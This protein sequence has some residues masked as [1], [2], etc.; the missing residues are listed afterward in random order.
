MDL[1]VGH[2]SPACPKAAVCVCAC[3]CKSVTMHWVIGLECSGHQVGE[4]AK[5]SSG[6]QLVASC[7][8]SG[9]GSR[10]APS[11]PGRKPHKNSCRR[12]PTPRQFT[13]Q[14]FSDTQLLSISYY[15]AIIHSRC[16]APTPSMAAPF[17]HS[18][19]HPAGCTRSN[20][21]PLKFAPSSKNVGKVRE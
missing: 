18:P 14:E 17:T 11:E 21:T 2:T 5:P 8:N 19:V 10:R 15:L 9:P 3:A 20:L 12:C 6:P 4:G 16:G 7:T 13:P 1:I